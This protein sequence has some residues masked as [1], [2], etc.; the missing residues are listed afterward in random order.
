ML[1]E[2]GEGY[3]SHPNDLYKVDDQVT[4]RVLDHD[5]K[6]RRI[7]LAVA[8]PEAEVAIPAGEEGE[9]APPPTAMEM[10]LREAFKEADEDFPV[11]RGRRQGR[12]R[13]PRVSRRKVQGTICL[14]GRS[15]KRKS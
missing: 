13:R 10:A 4:V 6:K 2:M 15:G 14:S 8:R 1:S 9:D 11:E 12:R 3:V 7:D 5:R